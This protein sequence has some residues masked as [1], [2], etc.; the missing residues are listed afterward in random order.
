MCEVWRLC[1]GER[2]RA[3]MA[4]VSSGLGV[5]CVASLITASKV[6][7]PPPLISFCMYSAAS[8]SVTIVLESITEML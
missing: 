1:K 7:R 4:G 8:Y 2:G 5:V 6:L 3:H